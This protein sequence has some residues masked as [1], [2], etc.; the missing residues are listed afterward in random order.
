MRTRCEAMCRTEAEAARRIG[1]LRQLAPE[2]RY[3]IEKVGSYW[4]IHSE[5]RSD[6]ASHPAAGS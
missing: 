2:R 3:W 6:D 5:P 1:T 4:S